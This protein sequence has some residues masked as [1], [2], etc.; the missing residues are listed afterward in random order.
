MMIPEMDLSGMPW[1]KS[2]R[3]NSGDACVE[4]VTLEAVTDDSTK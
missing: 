4:V 2:V 1:R 3:S